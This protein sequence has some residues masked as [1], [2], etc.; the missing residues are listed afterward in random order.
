MKEEFGNFLAGRNP[1]SI[2]VSSLKDKNLRQWTQHKRVVIPSQFRSVL[3]SRIEVGQLTWWS[4]RNPFSIQVSSL[5]YFPLR[6]C[7]PSSGR[8]PF[9][10]QVSSLIRTQKGT[11]IIKR[12]VIPSQFRSVLSI[13]E[14]EELHREIRVVIPS[15]FRSVLSVESMNGVI[16]V[17]LV[18]IPSQFRSV[19]S[20]IYR[21]R[22]V[23]WE[24]WVVIPSQF[25]SVL[26]EASKQNKEKHCVVIPSQFRSVLSNKDGRQTR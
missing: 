9:S 12:V 4:S 22:N 17:V 16:D 21:M 2:Q 8:N 15:Q 26:S 6:L 14:M 20:G 13:E 10:I 25:R 7:D 19:L 3:S 24:K 5:L 18:V 11:W 23:A 1:F